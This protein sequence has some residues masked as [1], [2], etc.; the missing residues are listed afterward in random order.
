MFV[1]VP[2]FLTKKAAVAAGPDP[3]W[4]NHPTMTTGSS[5]WHHPTSISIG[6][7]IAPSQV[8]KPQ[9][10]D[11][12]V[13]SCWF[14]VHCYAISCYTT[15]RW[16][17]TGYTMCQ[18]R[19]VSSGRNLQ[20]GSIKSSAMLSSIWWPLEIYPHGT[21]NKQVGRTGWNLLKPVEITAFV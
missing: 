2:T 10:G 7:S 18:K 11:L 19:L 15:L 1:N 6:Y 20:L 9:V 4:P 5:L 16:S 3:I 13:D 17:Y 14:W 12:G 21:K 8:H